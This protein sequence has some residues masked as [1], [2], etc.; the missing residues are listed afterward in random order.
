V[1]ATAPSPRALTFG[2]LVL[3]NIGRRRLRAVVT[4]LAVAIGITAVLG[5]GVLT[6]S[7][8]RTAI[9]V[10]RT[11]NADF[12]VSQRG[13]SDILYSA[14]DRQSLRR[15]QATPGVESA[16]GVFVATAHIDR[17]HP[18]FIEFGLDPKDSAEFGITVLRGRLPRA[19]ATDEMMIGW[20]A[21]EDFGLRVGDQFKIEERRFRV[22][23]IMTT[24][25]VFGDGAGMFPLEELRTWHR[26]PGVYTLIFV[27]TTPGADIKAVRA[28]IED[29][30]PRLATARAQSDYGRVDRN[31]VLI[32]AANVGGSI[33]A[34]F[35]GATG[36]MNTSLLS[37]F[38]RIYEFGVLRG[39]GWS[40][41]R[42]V[43]L[44][45]AEALVVAFVG[46][47]VGI[48]VGL[49]AVEG[50]TRVGSLVGVFQPYYDAAVFGRALAFAFGMAV[51]GAL[52]PAVRAGRL[53][54][55]EAIRHE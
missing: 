19:T 32:S 25:N 14:I 20:R 15:V 27:R 8:R 28:H 42:L 22:V 4:A 3:H 18:F 53:T 52:Y 2:G 55:L 43:A 23:G 36:V 47:A 34:L 48:V 51:L 21:A 24:G 1:A 38:E 5:L 10:L 30:N 17:Q 41:R 40:R 31:L 11:G 35:V 45:L 13:A 29:Q 6:S 50:L 49:V 7:L 39:C 16:V 12:S 33:L 26:Q 46:A 44:V 54:P 9:A 37:F